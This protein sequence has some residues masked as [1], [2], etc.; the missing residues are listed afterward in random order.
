MKEY[1]VI[2]G[3]ICGRYPDGKVA[4]RGENVE[5]R[6]ECR[7]DGVTIRLEDRSL[8]DFWLEIEVVVIDPD[9]GAAP[10]SVR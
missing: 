2:I 5:A 6:T 4:L 8:P 3:R 9:D 10:V 7:G 1:I